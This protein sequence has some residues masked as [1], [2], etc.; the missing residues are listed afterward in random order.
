MFLLFTTKSCRKIS[1]STQKERHTINELKN[2]PIKLVTW[3]TT[4]TTW[5][6]PEV[7]WCSSIL[8][9]VSGW[10]FT[11]LHRISARFYC[12]FCGR[13]TR[14]GS[15][16]SRHDALLYPL[17]GSL[18]VKMS[19]W[20]GQFAISVERWWAVGK[21]LW[22]SPFSGQTRL[23]VESSGGSQHF[24]KSSTKQTRRTQ[25]QNKMLL[26]VK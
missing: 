12:L 10:N 17:F 26:A 1:A 25:K 15:L 22:S 8:L 2:W 7:E 4:D 23:I 24:D 20:W 9:T 11:Y 5:G 21:F 18:V 19:R 14:L 3:L 6:W 16:I 13:I